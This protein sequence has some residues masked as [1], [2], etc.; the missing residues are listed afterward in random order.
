MAL[1]MAM[2]MAM[3]LVIV[4]ALEMVLEMAMSMTNIY[5]L[6][7]FEGEIA[8]IEKDNVTTDNVFIDLGFKREEAEYLVDM[9]NILTEVL[10]FADK[11]NFKKN[12]KLELKNILFKFLNNREREKNEI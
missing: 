6:K 1:A 10:K 3:A 2:A 11:Y 7:E 8:M 12:K 9:S 5:F 4:L